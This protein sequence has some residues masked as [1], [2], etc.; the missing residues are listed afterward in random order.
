MPFIYEKPAICSTIFAD[1]GGKEMQHITYLEIA[2]SD[3][4]PPDHSTVIYIFAHIIDVPSSSQRE[5]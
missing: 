4:Q 1:E 2:V 3:L 5:T